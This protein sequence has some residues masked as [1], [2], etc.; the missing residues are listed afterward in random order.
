[1]RAGDVERA[2]GLPDRARGDARDEP[3]PPAAEPDVRESM[4]DA[5]RAL[6]E[7]EERLARVAA[8][9]ANTQRRHD[10]DVARARRRDRAA[11]LAHWLPVVE[12]LERAAAHAGDA[13]ESSLREG[14]RAIARQAAEALSRAGVR[15]IP[16]TGEA[17]DPEAHE[18]VAHVSHGP[19]GMV[20]EEAAPGWRDED[21]TVL[22]HARVVVGG[23]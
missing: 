4:E 6:A 15:R 13:P 10:Q 17:F 2:S 19:A 23:R 9:L 12:S 14:L 5:Q 11:L 16:T 3:R 20:V 22:R 21:G 8:D 7:A 18:A 1:M